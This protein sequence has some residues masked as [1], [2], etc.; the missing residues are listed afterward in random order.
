MQVV[1]R[2]VLL[3]LTDDLV[4]DAYLSDFFMGEYYT[5]YSLI[6]PTRIVVHKS[7][8]VDDAV[9]IPEIMSN[10]IFNQIEEDFNSSHKEFN[11]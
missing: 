5:V 6:L 4:F 9:F 11:A 10:W 3:F 1:G 2:K 8:V 7:W